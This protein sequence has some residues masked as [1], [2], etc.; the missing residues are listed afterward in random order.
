MERN[1][2][3]IKREAFAKLNSIVKFNIKYLEDNNM[4]IKDFSLGDIDNNF[5]TED[6]KREISNSIKQIEGGRLESYC[7][8]QGINIPDKLKK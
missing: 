2:H 8:D 4:S 6:E 7:R 1:R 5:F 3:I